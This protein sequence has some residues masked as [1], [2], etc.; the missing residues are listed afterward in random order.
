MVGQRKG[1]SGHTEASRRSREDDPQV[2]Q[3]TSFSCDTQTM[4][5]ASNAPHSAWRVSPKVLHPETMHLWFHCSQVKILLSPSTYSA[6]VCR[7]APRLKTI[8]AWWMWNM[9]V[10]WFLFKHICFVF[11]LSINSLRFPRREQLMIPVG[12]VRPTPSNTMSGFTAKSQHTRLKC[13]ADNISDLQFLSA[14]CVWEIWRILWSWVPGWNSK[15]VPSQKIKVPS[16]YDFLWLC[17]GSKICFTGET[18]KCSG[19]V[20]FR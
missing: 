6:P 8:N 2:F 15:Y 5:A 16:L 17:R 10:W 20:C 13:W 4:N 14:A 9:H 1:I 19:N 12:K 3:P 18:F 11:L 7:P